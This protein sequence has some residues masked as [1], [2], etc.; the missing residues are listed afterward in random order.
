M[1]KIMWSNNR[2]QNIKEYSKNIFIKQYPNC[3]IF[4]EKNK[5]LNHIICAEYNYE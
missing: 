3:E 1:E 5:E 4:T 2:C